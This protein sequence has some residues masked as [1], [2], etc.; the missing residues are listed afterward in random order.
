MVKSKVTAESFL[1]NMGIGEPEVTAAGKRASGNI[2]GEVR[3]GPGR[4]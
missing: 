3:A 1:K 4:A 2:S